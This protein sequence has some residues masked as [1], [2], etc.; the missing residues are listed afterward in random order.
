MKILN[1]PN[2]LTISRIALVPVMVV[3]MMFPEN[4]WTCFFAG[5]FFAVAG[6]T[7][8]VDGYLARKDNQITRLGKF[9]DPLADKILVSSVLV[10]LVQNGRVPGWIAV[11]I[12]C[13]DV[14]VTGL[15]AIAADEGVVLA[16]DTYGKLKTVMQLV[17][18]GPLILHYPLL[19][20]PVRPIGMFL[21]YIAL[22]LTVFSGGNYFFNFYRD[23][24]IKTATQ[25]RQEG[26]GA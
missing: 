13:R 24:K 10:M 2:Q 6:F 17:A 7:D 4:P 20:I 12:I 18:I 1:L 22:V 9:L 15:R 11:V 8:L 26:N 23:W 25:G 16:A 3:L 14:M 19:G 21:L 5:L